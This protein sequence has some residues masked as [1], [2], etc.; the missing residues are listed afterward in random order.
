MST[1]VGPPVIEVH[2]LVVNLVPN[3]YHNTKSGDAQSDKVKNDI[4]Y[5]Y[6]LNKHSGNS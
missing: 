4:E 6:I 3:V 1:S 2:T 5:K